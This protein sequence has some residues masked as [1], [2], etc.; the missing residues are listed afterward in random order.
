M[1]KFLTKN[2]QLLAFGLGVLITILF[3]GS[4]I[5]GLEDFNMLSKEE[6]PTTNI[7]N[8]GIAGAIA[9]AVIA[10]VAAIVF[11]ILNTVMNLKG[12]IK[13][14]IGVAVLLVLFFALYAMAAP[15]TSGPLV[16]TIE[17]FNVTEGQS[18]F[19]SGAIN[20]SL[21][22]AG[23]AAAAFVISEVRNFFK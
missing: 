13:G 11:G 3:L 18:K 2:G 7:F 6:K 10:A 15:E 22:L 23:V 21:I 20:T 17:A 14:L 1:Y 4:V 16:S 9:L 19:I 8:L 5:P 12:S